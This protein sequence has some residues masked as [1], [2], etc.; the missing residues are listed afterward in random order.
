M[1]D[2]DR[3]RACL[4][5]AE[6]T[7]EMMRQRDEARAELAGERAAYEAKAG[8]RSPAAESQLALAMHWGALL[9]EQ[10]RSIAAVAS[11]YETVLRIISPTLTETS[12][13]LE[14]AMC[15]GRELAEG[16]V[17]WAIAR[18]EEAEAERDVA[19]G[20]LAALR[21]EV[22]AMPAIIT[23]VA[24]PGYYEGLALAQ[25]AKVRAEERAAYEE[26]RPKCDACGRR[27]YHQ[28]EVT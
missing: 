22:A 1:T 14:L 27:G 25:V 19:K 8:R 2:D 5:A 16:E 9:T 13:R 11:I 17:E 15:W 21:I 12:S 3:D 23:D 20:D 7:R 10:H 6:E 28:C 18:V 24:E 4:L 26:R